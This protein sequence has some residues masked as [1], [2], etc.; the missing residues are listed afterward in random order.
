M[1][2]LGAGSCS[3]RLFRRWLDRKVCN[4]SALDPEMQHGKSWHRRLLADH[5]DNPA[6]F[7]GCIGFLAMPTARAWVQTE[8]KWTQMYISRSNSAARRVVSSVLCAALGVYFTVGPTLP[9][10]AD[11]VAGPEKTKGGSRGAGFAGKPRGRDVQHAAEI[12]K[13]AIL[14]SDT[15]SASSQGSSGGAPLSSDPE[16]IR[17]VGLGRTEHGTLGGSIFVS[18]VPSILVV[19]A[20][21]LNEVAHGPEDLDLPTLRITDPRGRQW[22][23]DNRGP[24]SIPTV[25]YRGSSR[26]ETE[27]QSTIEQILAVFPNPV[28]LFDSDAS[29]WDILVSSETPGEWKINLMGSSPD[30]RVTC[31]IV[32]V[33]SFRA[34]ME[35]ALDA[36]GILNPCDDC[37]AWTRPAADFM[38]SAVITLGPYGLAVILCSASLLWPPLAPLCGA[39]IYIVIIWTDILA[40]LPPG[41]DS[42]LFPEVKEALANDLCKWLGQCNDISP[43]FVFLTGPSGGQTYSGN[44]AVSADAADASGVQY[45]EFHYSTDHASW[46]PV[47]GP[48]SPNGR[49]WYGDNGWSLRFDTQSAG[50]EYDESVWVRVRAADEY[51]NISGWDEIESSFIVD[52]RTNEPTAISVSEIVTPSTCYPLQIVN[53]SGAAIYNTG[54]PVSSATAVVRIS[55][56]NEWTTPVNPDGSYS[57]NFHAPSSSGSYAVQV[58]VS[59]GTLSGSNSRTLTVLDEPAGGSGYTFGRG[60]ICIDNTGAPDYLPVGETRSFEERDE[61]V[62]AWIEVNYVYQPVRFKFEFYRPNGALYGYPLVS[63]WT[64]DPQDFGWEYWEWWRFS[65]GWM[66]R[67]GST[68]YDIAG[69]EGVWRVEYYVD[70]GSGWDHHE[71][72]EFVMRYDFDEHR[73]CADVQSGDPWDPIDETNIFYQNDARAITWMKL[74]KVAVGPGVK[75]DFYE[76]DGSL[77][78]T[79][80]DVFE[81]PEDGGYEYWE[82]YKIW[83]WIWIDGW[84]AEH[85][86]GDWHVDVSIRNP[87]NGWD[88]EYTDYFRIEERP[89]ADP[90]PTVSSNPSSPLEGQPV[91]AVVS[92]TDNT[93]LESVNLY[94]LVSGES[95]PTTDSWNDILSPTFQTP[96]S[97]GSFQEQTTLELWVRAT[98]TSGNSAESQHHFVSFGDTDTE[99]PT[100]S[101]VQVHEANSGDQD[102]VIEEGECA[103]A[104]FLAVDPSGIGGGSIS[105]GEESWDVECTGSSCEGTTG[106][107][108]VGPQTLRI[109]VWDNDTSPA[110][111]QYETEIDVRPPDAEAPTME[112][113][114]EEEDQFYNVAPV[115][116]N[117]GFDDNSDLDRGGYVMND[118]GPAEWTLLFSD[119]AGASWDA[120]GWTIPLDVWNALPEGSNSIY[121]MAIDDAGNEG[122]ADCAWSWQ[123]NK[124]VSSPPA[125]INLTANGSNPS[126]PSQ[127]PLFV[128]DWQSPSDPSGTVAARY[129]LGEEPLVGE[130]GTRTTEHPFAIDV[131]SRGD[132]T[133]FVWLE[134]GAGNWDSQ[135]HSQ[136]VLQYIG[137]RQMTVTAPN[138][139]EQWLDDTQHVIAWTS[140]AIEHVRIE[141]GTVGSWTEIASAVPATYGSYLWLVPDHPGAWLVRICEDG[142]GIPCDESNAEFEIVNRDISISEGEHDFGDALV[143]QREEWTFNVS[144]VGSGIVT[145][146]STMV[147]PPFSTDYPE[148]AVSLAPGESLPI[149]VE[150]RPMDPSAFLEPLILVTNDPDESFLAVWLSGSGVPRAIDILCVDHDGSAWNPDYADDWPDHRRAVA[151]LR[152]PRDP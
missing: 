52:N 151:G 33:D 75:W 108:S 81:D 142:D 87:W 48:D 125:P 22:S 92:V 116:S 61:V 120:D 44:I 98:D 90:Q 111:S 27:I 60:T 43:P 56:V 14:G 7:R 141:Y 134:D 71:S 152:L 122:G 1:P 3:A 145:I 25:V 57:R 21:F 119:W 18:S 6:T 69:M 103:T 107:L 113:I 66:I 144:N 138:G 131:S 23:S 149:T 83:G 67:E 63:D 146:L 105:V 31:S 65:W 29:R 91:S 49:D 128:I 70:D 13:L 89:P 42:F 4:H 9:V 110:P 12:P 37:M 17:T 73:L 47:V 38:I 96:V 2:G 133:L 123:F 58:S 54:E 132:Q 11:E 76:P 139:G 77:Y 72:L 35:V 135:N 24:L 104:T 51:D 115:F 114:A 136:A 121:F 59:D 99:G 109:V 19:R 45:V 80:E 26:S 148:G 64:D 129:R 102:G 118:C 143:G 78:D 88:V 94:C 15:P 100:I 74:D 30:D 34:Q 10:W 41:W 112:T 95:S 126:P 39:G 97:L 85:K 106:P 50:I 82:W 130:P 40:F 147:Q 8:R 79:F 5:L 137:D 140:T 16:C 127:D 46:F 101:D 55:G 86:C 32:D 20:C 84:A 124:D 28:G 36:R 68:I 62:L 150:F 53:V 117:L 93:Y